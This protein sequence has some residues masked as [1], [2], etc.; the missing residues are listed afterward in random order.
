MP[1]SEAPTRFVRPF[2]LDGVGA[3]L[4]RL[5]GADVAD[6]AVAVVIPTLAWN[7]IRD[8]FTQLVRSRR[9]NCVEHG[10]R[11]CAAGAVGEKVRGR[12]DGAAG[13]VGRRQ[14]RVARLPVDVALVAAEGGA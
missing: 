12:G 8:R 6:L 2:Q 3:E 5:P 1:C 7:R 14:D 10:E 9:C 13:G 11:A 4:L